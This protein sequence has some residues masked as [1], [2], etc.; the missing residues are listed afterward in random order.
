MGSETA[1]ASQHLEH[2]GGRLFDWYDSLLGAF[3]SEKHLGDRIELEIGRVDTDGFADAGAGLSEEQ[4]KC[5]VPPSDARAAL[6]DFEERTELGAAEMVE[7][8]LY[9]AFSRDGEDPLHDAHRRRV[10]ERHV[11]EE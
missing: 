4:Q 5:V 8:W 7:D 6:R 1:L 10:F 11:V 9:R 2:G 3:S